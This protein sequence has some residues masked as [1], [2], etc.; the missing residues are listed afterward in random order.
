MKRTL[1]AM[2][3]AAVLLPA[4]AAVLRTDDFSKGLRGWNT[5]GYW[6]GKTTQTVENGTKFLLLESGVRDGTEIFGRAFSAGGKQIPY[7]PGDSIVIKIKAKGKGTLGS[8]VLTYC[9]GSGAP[10]YARG[11][12]HILTPEFKTYEFKSELTERFRQILPYMEIKGEGKA[13]VA[14]F[15]METVS[16]PSVSVKT[17]TGLRIASVKSPGKPIV[18]QTSVKNGDVAVSCKTGEIKA[19]SK[20]EKTSADGSLSVPTDKL[21]QGFHEV[22]VSKAGNSATSYID[23]LP[24]DI[25]RATDATARKIKLNKPVKVLFLGDSLSDFYRGYN[26]IDR[27]NFWVGKYNPG[28]FSFRNAGVGGDFCK[29]LL[30]R[31]YGEIA[32]K[33]LAYRQEMYDGLFKEKY[34]LVFLFLGQ[35]DTRCFRKDGFSKQETPPELQKKCLTEIRKILKEKCPGAELVLVSP[36]PSDEDLFIKRDQKLPK[37]A[38]M[39]MY[40]K[41]EFVDLYDAENRKFCKEENIPYID[42][43]SVMRAVSPIKSLYVTDGIHLSP[44]GGRVIADEILKFLA[45]KYR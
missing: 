11:G 35:N 32:G 39:V 22:S 27:I 19:S 1:T 25:F 33:K 36:S 5:P 34:D 13:V 37:G 6:A 42:I 8:G 16:D 31:L 24:E 21:T 38:Y 2:M 18:F 41:K 14:S 20:Q 23:V 4:S 12:E 9:F 26:Y 28:K 45:E 30:D 7:F 15:S 40:G 17:D 44:A 43:L 29:R 3:L 10:Q